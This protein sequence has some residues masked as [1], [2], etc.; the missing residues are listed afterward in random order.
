MLPELFVS[1]LFMLQAQTEPGFWTSHSNVQGSA[2]SLA[3]LS[4]QAL[5]R[6]S[7]SINEIKLKKRL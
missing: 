1:C 7:K 5:R 2:D 6:V 3:C 4:L